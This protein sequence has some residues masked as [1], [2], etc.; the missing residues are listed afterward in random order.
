MS[1]ETNE[2][3]QKLATAVAILAHAVSSTAGAEAVSAVFEAEHALI[4]ALQN[5]PISTPKQ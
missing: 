5:E 3:L 1:A 4:D 2:A